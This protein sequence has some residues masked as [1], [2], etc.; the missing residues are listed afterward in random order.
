MG[1]EVK[2]FELESYIDKKSK[3]VTRRFIDLPSYINQKDFFKYDN[4]QIGAS[5]IYKYDKWYVWCASTYQE[6]NETFIIVKSKEELS[7]ES[8]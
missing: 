2:L 3:V 8:I 5:H 4:P 6:S 7:N 1:K